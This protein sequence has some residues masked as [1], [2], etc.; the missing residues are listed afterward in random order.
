MTKGVSGLTLTLREFNDGRR[1]LPLEAVFRALDGRDVD[2]EGDPCHVE[3]CGVYDDGG[4]RWVQLALAGQRP[5]MMTIR[6]GA[7]PLDVVSKFN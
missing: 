5:R 2:V 1:D 3:V 6:L 7:E 4:R